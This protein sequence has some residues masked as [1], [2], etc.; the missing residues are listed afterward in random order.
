M[1]VYSAPCVICK[2]ELLNHDRAGSI[3]ACGHAQFHDRCLDDWRRDH[4]RCPECK[5]KTPLCMVRK[6]VIYVRAAD[7]QAATSQYRKTR[8]LNGHRV[9]ALEPH[10][11][12]SHVQPGDIVYC[13]H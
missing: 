1:E 11:T 9:Q 5:C 8:Q 7:A 4:G 6:P 3:Y 12:L 13:V 2:K 10:D